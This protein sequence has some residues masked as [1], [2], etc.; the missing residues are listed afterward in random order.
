M[1]DV[2]QVDV[3]ERNAFEVLCLIL[4][5]WKNK[6]APINEIPPEIL[7]LKASFRTFGIRAREIKTS[8]H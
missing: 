6:V 8:S 1:R 4:N 2:F 5:V 7:A 3:L